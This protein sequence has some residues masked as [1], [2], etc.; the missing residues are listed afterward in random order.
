[1]FLVRLSLGSVF[2]VKPAVASNVLLEGEPS[3]TVRTRVG[4]VQ[5]GL[6]AAARPEARVETS[7]W[8]R[9]GQILSSDWWK[10]YYAITTHLNT[11]KF[12]P[13][14]GI[15]CLLLCRY[16]IISGS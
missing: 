3:L 8:S 12:P 5:L 7:H 6:P 16:G 14:E 15:L 13:L 10:S 9:S 1:M 11:T 4:I 2:V